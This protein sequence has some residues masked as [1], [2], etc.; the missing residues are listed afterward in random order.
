MKNVDV[1]TRPNLARLCAVSEAARSSLSIPPLVLT[2]LLGGKGL[3]LES[4]TDQALRTF[5]TRF[6]VSH[7]P[8][9][10]EFRS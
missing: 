8:A 6:F 10:P 7:R 1:D 9:G 2:K 5:L 3:K 4:L